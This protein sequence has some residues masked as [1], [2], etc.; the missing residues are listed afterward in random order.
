[1]FESAERIL[2]I[3]ALALLFAQD[4]KS[5]PEWVRKQVRF[6]VHPFGLAMS[7]SILKSGVRHINLLAYPGYTEPSVD[8]MV[9]VARWVMAMKDPPSLRIIYGQLSAEVNKH[10]DVFFELG[11]CCDSYIVGGCKLGYNG[12]GPQGTKKLEG[13]FHFLSIVFDVDIQ[14]ISTSKS[15]TERAVKMLEH[16]WDEAEREWRTE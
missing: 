5:C 3:D 10:R 7:P 2:A 4:N 1:M 11:T 12:E 13:L 16:A 9:G 15:V 14:R 8:A 6:E